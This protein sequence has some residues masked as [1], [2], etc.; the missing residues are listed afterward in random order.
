[1]RNKLFIL[2]LFFALSVSTAIAQNVDED[3]DTDLDVENSSQIVDGNGY[4]Y[5][6]A[7]S[8]TSMRRCGVTEESIKARGFTVFVKLDA[9]LSATNMQYCNKKTRRAGRTNRLGARYGHRR[10]VLGP[11]GGVWVNPNMPGV[12]IAAGCLNEFHGNLPAKKPVYVPPVKPPVRPDMCVNRPNISQEEWRDLGDGYEVSEDGRCIKPTKSPTPEA[13]PQAPPCPTCPK[14]TKSKGKT[15]KKERFLGG[16]KEAGVSC[17]GGY[18][19]YG[20]TTGDWGLNALFRGCLPSVGVQRVQQALNPSQD[21]LVISGDT[22]DTFQ[23]KKGEEYETQDNHWKVTWDGATAYIYYDGQLCHVHTLGKTSNIAVLAI[24]KAKN[25]N[26]AKKKTQSLP[27]I[28]G[29]MGTG[30]TTTN[31]PRDPRNP[32]SQ[33]GSNNGGVSPRGFH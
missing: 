24:P 10:I 22:F 9:P 26:T 29:G 7:E 13:T 23:V 25:S 2:L 32:R 14:G 12:L 28:R 5:P 16:K 20:G 15:S 6:S 11:G 1:M 19:A 8:P 17:G 30:G 4:F 27:P 18:V 21:I 31:I 3:M 33:Q